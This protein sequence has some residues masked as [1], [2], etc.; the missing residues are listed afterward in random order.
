MKNFKISVKDIAVCALFAALIAICS[1][2]SVP[3]EP[4]PINLAFLAIFLASGIIGGKRAAIATVVFI[5]VGAVGAPVFSG[6][7]SGLGTLFGPTGG[8]IIGY[9]FTAFITGLLIEKFKPVSNVIPMI[10][11]VLATYIPGTIW[12]MAVY[13]GADG[14][15]AS[16]ASAL[17]W[18]V[19]PFIVFDAVKVL[20]ANE[21]TLR[22]APLYKKMFA[23]TAPAE[24]TV[25]ENNK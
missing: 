13:R 8:Y 20:I 11:G 4:V 21:L 12:F 1:M 19:L 22:I 23:G 10:I 16:L 9:I 5:L 14:S 2:T 18:C 17:A 15:H 24:I 6:Y 25:E 7:T 3:L